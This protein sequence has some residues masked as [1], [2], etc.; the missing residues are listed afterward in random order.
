MAAAAVVAEVE[1][2]ADPGRVEGAARI[3]AVVV[4]VAGAVG[5]E[6]A[7]QGTEPEKVRISQKIDQSRGHSI[8]QRSCPGGARRFVAEPGPAL[9]VAAAGTGG[10]VAE[11]RPDQ[12]L[13]READDKKAVGQK[14]RR[15]TC[16]AGHYRSCYR[17]ALRARGT[18]F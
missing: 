1:V 14:A 12:G 4:V 5:V 2:E 13:K 3:V 9:A 18:L 10:V 17:S 16:K 15:Q 6:S 7:A 11:G 8:G